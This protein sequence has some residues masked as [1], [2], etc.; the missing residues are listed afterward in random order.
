MMNGK[1]HERK[2]R[3]GKIRFVAILRL[4]VVQ[5]LTRERPDRGPAPAGVGVGVGEESSR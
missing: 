5:A 1:R 2:G 4:R 3:R